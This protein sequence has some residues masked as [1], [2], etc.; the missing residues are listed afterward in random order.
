MLHVLCALWLLT[1]FPLYASA[2]TR[3][4]VNNTRTA[5][6]FPYWHATCRA[7]EKWSNIKNT[8]FN[9]INP[10]RATGLFRYPPK[11]SENQR[12]SD[13]FRRYGKRPVAWNG[14]MPH[15]TL[16]NTIPN[17]YQVAVPEQLIVHRT[18][19]KLN[20]TFGYQL[21]LNQPLHSLLE[22]ILQV[23]L[24]LNEHD[25]SKTK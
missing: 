3:D 15:T 17:E 6:M 10:C 9:F 13:V 19:C 8:K 20:A 21:G 4:S 23:K 5:A 11:K 24:N 7:D 14:L 2:F 16:N 1:Y 12:F 25:Q 18:D 22:L